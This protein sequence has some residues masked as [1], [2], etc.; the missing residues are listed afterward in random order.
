MTTNDTIDSEFASVDAAQTPADGL[1]AD[2]TAEASSFVVDEVAE[3]DVSSAA[4][5]S[6]ELVIK[7]RNVAVPQH[8]RA[9]VSDKLAKLERFDSTIYL[10]G[11]ELQHEP[12]RRQAK[13]CQRVEL[14]ATGKGPVVRAEACAENF[15]AALELAI[16]KLE[17]RL[18]RSHDRRTV[19]HGRHR[20]LSVAE[21][22]AS[23]ATVDDTVED[24]AEPAPDDDGPGRIV[25]I[26]EHPA[27]P[28]SVDD[29]LYEMELVGHDFFLFQCAD[30]NQP[31]VVYR[32]H[33][34][35]YGVIR[36]V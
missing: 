11:I 9:F 30:T 5:T 7:G 25:R 32:R 10:F 2:E 15:R 29:A 21:A 14:T 17:G 22:T 1:P 28:M 20:P 4:Q 36:L 34:F 24:T 26:K 12:N 3:A 16:D 35:D 8:F 33:A 23:L 13:N 6:A 18:R 31:S 27:V 19:H